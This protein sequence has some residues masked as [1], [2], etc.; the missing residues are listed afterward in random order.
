L[1]MTLS[2]A[3]VFIPLVLLPGLLGRIFQEFSITIIV[4]ILASALGSLTLT[5]LLCA[6]I[7]GE[8][9]AGHKRA[10]MEKWTGNFIKRVIDVYSRALDKFLDR[11]W[12]T[13]AILLTCI[14]GLGY[15][16][17]HFPF[18]LLPPGYSCFA[19]GRFFA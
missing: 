2:L 11:A 12:L 9:R 5:P 6:R 10:R 19:R 3:A 16:F 18:T 13:I 14:L 15:V 7:L 4:A 17:T 1:S 8:R